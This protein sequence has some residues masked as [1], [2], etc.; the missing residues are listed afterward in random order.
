[1]KKSATR[2]RVRIIGFDASLKKVGA[3]TRVG[4]NL[5]DPGPKVQKSAALLHKGAAAATK[6]LRGGDL[7]TAAKLAAAL[8]AEAWSAR[9]LVTEF[10]SACYFEG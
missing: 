2:S 4:G 3:D 9:K 1:M 6:A 5:E 8:A 10:A 7:A